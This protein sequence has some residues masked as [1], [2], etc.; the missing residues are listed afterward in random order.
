MLHIND[1][2]TDNTVLSHNLIDFQ[3]THPPS[4]PPAEPSLT[5]FSASPA[6][7]QTARSAASATAGLLLATGNLIIATTAE[8]ENPSKNTKITV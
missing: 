8:V 2:Y 5:L 4:Q 1:K 6:R 3:S 7:Y